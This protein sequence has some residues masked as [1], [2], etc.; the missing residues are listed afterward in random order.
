[1]LREKL[2]IKKREKVM[3]FLSLVFNTL[4]TREY[5]LDCSQSDAQKILDALQTVTTNAIEADAQF[6]NHPKKLLDTNSLQGRNTVIAAMCGFSQVTGLYPTQLLIKEPPTTLAD[7]PVTAGGFADV[8]KVVFQG[9]DMCFKESYIKP[10]PDHV[11][12][13]HAK[14]A[15]LWAQ[16]LHPNIL[17]FFG[18][19]RIESQLA[20][21]SPWALNGNLVN[22]LVHNPHVNRLLL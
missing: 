15:I 9:H 19:A 10:P 3:A 2:L 5:L 12:K 1:M 13:M 6:L 22:Y 14:E 4:A 11:A 20:F 21:V 16:L 17:P 7:E 8:F 18:L